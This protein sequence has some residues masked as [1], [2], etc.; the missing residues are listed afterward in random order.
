MYLILHPG[1]EIKELSSF[2]AGVQVEGEEALI[3]APRHPLAVQGYK[4]KEKRPTKSYYAAIDRGHVPRTGAC[5][6][7]IRGKASDKE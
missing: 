6:R 1:P 7:S 5:V 2:C 4:C 3:L